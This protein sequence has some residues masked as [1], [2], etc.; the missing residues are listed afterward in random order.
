MNSALPSDLKN[1]AFC[2]VMQGTHK[3]KS[4]TVRGT[5]S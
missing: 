1:G 4:G 3:G 2:N 5:G